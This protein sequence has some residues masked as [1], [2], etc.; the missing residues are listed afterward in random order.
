MIC[1]LGRPYCG[2]VHISAVW[3]SDLSHYCHE[4]WDGSVGEQK[5][6]FW[7][8]VQTWERVGYPLA[9]DS[10]PMALLTLKRYEHERKVMGHGVDL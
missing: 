10:G 5:Q 3:G 2:S 7:V 6:V 8:V 4:W 9:V 1:W